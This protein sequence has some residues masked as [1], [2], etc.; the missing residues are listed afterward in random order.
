M[1]LFNKKINENSASFKRKLA[2]RIVTHD[3]KYITERINDSDVVISK[4]G[5]MHIID[6]ILTV[7]SSY[8]YGSKTI[9][10]CEVDKLTP[11]EL[12]SLEGGIFE[13]PDMSHDGQYRKIIV[14]YV[15]YR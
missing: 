12:F 5:D 10:R 14:Y 11:S 4:G 13:G 6:G 15:Y 1:G 8:E 2:E 9:F 3:I 7:R